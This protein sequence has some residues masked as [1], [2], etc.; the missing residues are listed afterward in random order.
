VGCP[1]EQRV[2]PGRVIAARAQWCICHFQVGQGTILARH[3]LG[4]KG[5]VLLEKSSLPAQASR[6]VPVAAA[7]VAA[8]NGGRPECNSE[9]TKTPH[10][11]G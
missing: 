3:R 6:L 11:E 8:V 2:T 5:L 4:F 9:L 1:Q 10:A 7:S